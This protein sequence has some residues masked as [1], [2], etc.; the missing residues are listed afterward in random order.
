M[1]ETMQV[2]LNGQLTILKSQLEE[3]AIFLPIF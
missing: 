3:L 1:A 2:N